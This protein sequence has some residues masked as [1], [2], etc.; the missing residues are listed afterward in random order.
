MLYQDKQ[1]MDQFQ[2]SVTKDVNNGQI[3]VVQTLFIQMEIKQ[4]M[5]TFV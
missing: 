4:H 2:E 1:I 3:N 5:I